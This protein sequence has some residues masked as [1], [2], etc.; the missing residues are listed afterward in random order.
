MLL[1][2]VA[3]PA[4]IEVRADTIPSGQLNVSW[5]A[6]W[7]STPTAE[8]S[9]KA[10][11]GSSTWT[12]LV[13]FEVKQAGS[14]LPSAS[15]QFAGVQND[16]YSF[17]TDINVEMKGNG[18]PTS[19]AVDSAK[20]S[21]LN[22]EQAGYLYAHN[23]FNTTANPLGAFNVGPNGTTVNTLQ[24]AAL[25]LA[26][27]ETIYQ[28]SDFN[29]NLF[30]HDDGISDSD[31][32]QINQYA[33]EMLNELQGATLTPVTILEG[34]GT[35]SLLGLPTGTGSTSNSVPDAG[36]TLAL[37]GMACTCLG[38]VGRRLRR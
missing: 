24:A 17:C 10:L 13:P 12:Y 16:F 31:K 29:W 1:A 38:V 5:N 7:Q 11:N 9:S 30:L 4:A 6:Q 8:I 19:Y 27:W 14:W 15:G 32:D 23:Y 20:G 34:D 21:Q 35:Q 22:Y 37:L 2:L 26:I 3:A 33:R 18:Y 36:F 28:G 25:Q